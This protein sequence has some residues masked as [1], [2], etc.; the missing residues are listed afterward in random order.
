MKTSRIKTNKCLKVAP[1]LFRWAS[2]IYIYSNTNTRNVLISGSTIC[3]LC[4]IC[5]Y[6]NLLYCYV[7]LVAFAVAKYIFKQ[8]MS[9]IYFE[10]ADQEKSQRHQL[11]VGVGNYILFVLNTA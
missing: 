8:Q 9:F 11:A 10:Y 5:R 7:L 4:L 1:A 3:R 6:Y 2:P